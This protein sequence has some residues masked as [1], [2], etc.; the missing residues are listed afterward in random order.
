MKRILALIDFSSVTAAVVK[1]ARDLARAFDG[2]LTLV[3]VVQTESDFDDAAVEENRAG[4]AV[5]R[6]AH[7]REM[8]ILT[9]A[10]RKEGITVAAHVVEARSPGENV[11]G[12]ILKE[13]AKLSPDLVVLGSHG[14]GRLYQLL[15]GSV[16]DTVIHKVAYPVLIVPSSKA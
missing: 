7:Q 11:I 5:T 6:L 12:K 3:H 16:T 1:I 10:L 15:V 13:L 4:L 9:I 14:H 2:E 8:E